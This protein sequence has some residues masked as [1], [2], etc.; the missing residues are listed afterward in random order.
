MKKAYFIGPGLLILAIGGFF[1]FASIARAPK[2]PATPSPVPVVA[3]TTPAVTNVSQSMDEKNDAQK[4]SVSVK[5]PQFA[6]VADEQTQATIN[7]LIKSKMQKDVTAFK[8]E[9]AANT[10]P[11]ELK[12]AQAELLI[13]YTVVQSGP[14]YISVQF[15]VM[16]SQVGMA[17]PNNYNEVFNYDLEE[18][19]EVKLADLFKKD[20]NY[21]K[22]LSNISHESLIAQ[23]KDDPAAPTLVDAGTGAKASNFILFTLSSSDLILLFD[24]AT[25]APSFNGTMKVTIPWGDISDLL[26]SEV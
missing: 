14:R 7:T 6:G 11:P 26:A 20:S 1:Y 17:H 8:K 2:I 22:I 19:K 15:E 24:P 9:V 10:P 13:K 16:D 23:Q 12:D 4:Y 5:Y 21:L 25:V 18:K 3:S